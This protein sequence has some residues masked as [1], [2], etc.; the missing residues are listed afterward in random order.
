[1]KMGM[2][3][4]T[5]HITGADLLDRWE[6]KTTT[7][8]GPAVPASSSRRDVAPARLFVTAMPWPRAY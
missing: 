7:D 2:F 1:M 4:S 3:D 6:E 5:V 8:A